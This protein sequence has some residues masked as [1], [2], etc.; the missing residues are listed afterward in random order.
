MAWLESYFQT[1]WYGGRR[2]F[3]LLRPLEALYR[4]VVSK[5]RQTFLSNQSSIYKPRAPV[6]VVGNITVG[7]T[8]KTPLTIH[9]IEALLERG[10]RVGVIS[11]GYGGKASKYPVLIDE[12]SAASEVG[13]EP[14]MISQRTGVPVV[15]D[16]DRVSAAKFLESANDLDIIIS[17]DGLQHYK[18]WRSLEIVVMDVTRGIGNGRCLPCGPLREPLCRLE[19][20]DFLVINGANTSTLPSNIESQFRVHGAP[21]ELPTLYP[22][23][24]RADDVVALSGREQEVLECQEVYGVAGI[25]NPSRFYT[26]LSEVGYQVIERP[27]PDHHHFQQSDFS[28]MQDKPVVMTEKD[29]VKVVSLGLV[30][31]WYLRVSAQLESTL[32]DD[33]ISKISL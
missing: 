2:P 33:I 4:R 5:K 19:S 12:R 7:G 26:T 10:L 29:A 20:V 15:V 17:D 32:I 14:L 24:I 23:N 1:V 21:L 27:F 8:G 30:N 25:G 6:L 11:R 3:V 16:P 18:L 9:L 13:D 28:L 22:M 31:G